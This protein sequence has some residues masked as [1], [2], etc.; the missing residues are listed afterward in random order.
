[1]HRLGL[2]PLILGLLAT[3][4]QAVTVRV[5]TVESLVEA[6][7][8]SA[9]ARVVA[10]DH[11]L[12]SA[13]ISGLIDA[14]RVRVGERVVAGQALVQ[15]ECHDYDL[16]LQQARSNLDSLD[17]R[18]RLAHQQLERAKTLVKQRNASVEL[19]DQRQSELDQQV[20]ERAGAVLVIDKA[21]LAVKRC[22]VNA[23]FDGVVTERLASEGSLASP[24][25]PLLKLLRDQALEVEAEVPLEQVES[26][27]RAQQRA[28][29][30]DGRRYPLTLRSVVPLVDSRTRTRPIRLVFGD[31]AALAGSSGRLVWQAPQPR[32][33]ASLMVRRGGQLGLMLYDG[34]RARFAPLP[35]AREGQAAEVD[36]PRGSLVIVEGQQVLNDGDE[37]ER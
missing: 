23:P 28:F 24:G 9:P 34:G 20:A 7:E 33:P 32:L 3:A 17:A 8:Y 25:T 27:R 30:N 36:L 13:Q 19:R 16:A 2:L 18:I 29:V 12:L 35:D 15:L 26:L 4:A 11:S 14:I 10:E 31:D 21:Q 5:A 1:M 6:V 22:S 37:V